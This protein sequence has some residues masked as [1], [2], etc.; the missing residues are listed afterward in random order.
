MKLVRR[1]R[2]AVPKTAARPGHHTPGFPVEPPKSSRQVVC[3]CNLS[4]VGVAC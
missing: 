3:D 2:T 1:G 4:R